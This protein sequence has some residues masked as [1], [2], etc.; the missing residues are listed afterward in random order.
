MERIHIEGLELYAYHGC[1][2]DERRE[3]QVFLLDITAQADLAAAC[4]SD[5]LR[6][7]VD[8]SQMIQ[9]AAAAFAGEPCRLVERAAH[10]CA[11]AL[12]ERFPAMESVTLRA[13]KPDAPVQSPV[14]DI[15]V[16][17]QRGRNGAGNE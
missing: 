13:H 7:T 4:Q 1:N 17:I 5:D 15:Y 11:Q 3:G 6:D 9:C 2:E 16:E 10:R 14:A 8:Y 12:L